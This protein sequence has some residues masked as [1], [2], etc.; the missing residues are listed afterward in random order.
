VRPALRAIVLADGEPCTRRGLDAAWPE[1]DSGIGLVVAADGGARLADRLGL[2][3]DRW[4]GDGD[5]LGE[6]GLAD[7]R[8]RGIPTDLMPID[9][10]E[11]DAELALA[12]ALDAGADD[13]TMLGALGGKRVDHALAN[14]AL[15]AHPRLVGRTARLLDD[16]SRVRLLRAPGPAGQPVLEPLP[17]P[18]GSMVSLIPLGVTAE[19]VTTHGMRYPLSGDA[20]PPGPS[21][22]LSNVRVAEAASVTL[23]AGLLLIVEVPATLGP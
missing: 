5:S 11:T 17:G 1:W 9:K 20:V 8:A 4:V 22:G 18:V 13:I 16:R 14:V 12:A 6:P 10:D 15:L 3:I 23:A 21:R 19:G 7:L 2:G